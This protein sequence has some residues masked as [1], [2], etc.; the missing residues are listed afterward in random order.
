MKQAKVLIVMGSRSDLPAMEGC[1]EQL[2][3]FQ[4]PYLVRILSAHRTPEAVLELS[5]EAQ[6]QGIQVIIAAAG[7]A[8]HLAGVLASSTVLP[9]IGIPM[10]TSALGG[11]DS[12]LST[13]QM[14]SGVPVATVAIGKAGA[15]NAAI[16]ACQMIGLQ[17]P[18]IQEKVKVFK[19]EQAKK[20]LA[21]SIYE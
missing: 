10:Q 4:V 5:K 20:V 7:G 1:M 11:M 21:D 13:V 6:S 2:D 19:Q 3:A 12:L 16:L 15:K 18:A 8:A 17:D 14:P 9:V